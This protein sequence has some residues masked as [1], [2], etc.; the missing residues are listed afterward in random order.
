MGALVAVA[1]AWPSR[2]RCQSWQRWVRVAA[3]W[4]AGLESHHASELVTFRICFPTNGRVKAQPLISRLDFGWRQ[5]LANL[6][7]FYVIVGET[8]LLLLHV[9]KVEA[10][11]RNG[12]PGE[13]QSTVEPRD[14]ESSCRA[15]VASSIRGDSSQVERYLMHWQRRCN[16]QKSAV[17]S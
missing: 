17:R 10:K 2:T 13:K 14:V 8:G 15:P 11:S 16:L 4:S 6:A 9:G 12:L 7:R 1:R 5:V 3:G